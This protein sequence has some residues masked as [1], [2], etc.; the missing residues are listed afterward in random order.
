MAPCKIAQQRARSLLEMRVMSFARYFLTAVYSK[1]YG[2]CPKVL[3]CKKNKGRLDCVALKIIFLQRILKQLLKAKG[4]INLGKNC[5]KQKDLSAS[6]VTTDQITNKS[7]VVGSVS[8]SIALLNFS[9]PFLQKIIWCFK[10]Q[11]NLKFVNIFPAAIIFCWAANSK[12]SRKFL[13]VTIAM[14]WTLKKS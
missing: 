7:D 14:V 3:G 6:T 5:I 11:G 8:Y 13:P 4:N 10:W 9:M 2:A 1:F 12:I